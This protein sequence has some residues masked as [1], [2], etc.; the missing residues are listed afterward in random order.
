MIKALLVDDEYVASKALSNLL[1]TYCPNVEI[2]GIA[3][4]VA[5]AYDIISIENPNLVFLDVMMPGE[6]GF[7]LLKKFDVIPFDII[8]TTAYHD[9]ALQAI[10]YS[11]VDYLLKPIELKELKNAIDKITLN[12]MKAAAQNRPFSVERIMIHTE[13]SILFINPIEVIRLEAID[14]KLFFMMKNGTK[15]HVY[16][17]FSDYES[18]FTAF[19]F[20]RPHR[21]HLINLNEIKEYVYDKNG[22]CIIMD[23]KKLI[24]LSINKRAEFLTLFNKIF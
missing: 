16:K 17:K 5:A 3:D 24:P 23:D 8:F 10:K 18:A 14:K 15:F 20:F 13:K 7:S 9:Y 19:G 2:C 22:G 4:S 21:S 6:D 12:R 11:A 1:E